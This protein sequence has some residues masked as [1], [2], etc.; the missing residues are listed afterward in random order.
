MY[1]T[2]HFHLSRVKRIKTPTKNKKAPDFI[3]EPVPLTLFPLL[4]RR[5]AMNAVNRDLT[6]ENT[7]EG[8]TNFSS[9]VKSNLCRASQLKIVEIPDT[10]I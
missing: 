4:S 5:R 3:P 1:F 6:G 10:I 8:V 9:L 7:K 2:I